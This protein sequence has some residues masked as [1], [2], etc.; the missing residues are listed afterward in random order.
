M[1][2]G[3]IAHTCLIEK[4]TVLEKLTD[5]TALKATCD[6]D[7]TV[8]KGLGVICNKNLVSSNDNLETSNKNLANTDKEKK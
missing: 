5:M 2:H 4:Q 7:L 3:G 1:M 6:S 8:S